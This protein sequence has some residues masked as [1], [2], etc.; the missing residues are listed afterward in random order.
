MSVAKP[1]NISSS[2]LSKGAPSKTFISN[3]TRLAKIYSSN[4]FPPSEGRPS[5]SACFHAVA[6]HRI[7][8]ANNYGKT[9]FYLSKLRKERHS[10]CICMFLNLPVWANFYDLTDL[11]TYQYQYQYDFRQTSYFGLTQP[12]PQPKPG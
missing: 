9:P 12:K 5:R 2:R 11:S 7:C 10:N 3:K 8:I 4:I 1:I 6:M